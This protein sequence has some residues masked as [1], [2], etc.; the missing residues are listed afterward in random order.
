MNAQAIPFAVAFLAVSI[1]LTA[2]VIRHLY[3]MGYRMSCDAEA[4]RTGRYGHFPLGSM[5]TLYRYQADEYPSEGQSDEVVLCISFVFIR[6]TAEIT[7]H[8]P[9]P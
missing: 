2:G 1:A 3:N 8:Y 9:K 6:V 4:T 7:L 5:I